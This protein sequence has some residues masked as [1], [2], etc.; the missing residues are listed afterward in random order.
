MRRH[1][2]IDL[3]ECPHCH[4]RTRILSTIHPPQTTRTTRAKTRACSRPSRIAS[5]RPLG[6]LKRRRIRQRRPNFTSDKPNSV[7]IPHDEG[8]ASPNRADPAL[9]IAAFGHD[10]EHAVE[11]RKVR[12]EDFADSDAFKAAHAR[13]SAAMLGG[14]PRECGVEEETLTREVHRLVCLHE[15]GGDLPL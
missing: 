8:S 1:F 2:A 14:I 6:S 4:G 11:A 9:R 15:V 3:F 12:R 5:S 7:N 13:N 10:I